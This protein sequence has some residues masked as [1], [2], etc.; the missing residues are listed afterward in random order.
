MLDLGSTESRTVNGTELAVLETGEGDPLVLVHGGVSDLRSWSGQI[1]AFSERFR[2]IAYSRRF[3]RP[4]APIPPD[5]GDPIQTH[6]DDLAA[7][8]GACRASPAHVIGHSWGGLASLMLALQRPELCR[9]LV[10]IEPPMVSMH[11]TIPPKPSRL[12]RL[13]VRSPR[14]ALAIIRFGAGAMAAADKAFRRGDDKEA[15]ERLG[16]GV[17]GD[18]AFE[19]LSE[20]RYRQV[21]DNR[22]PDRAQ[23]LHHEFP[24]LIDARFS[25]MTLPVLLINGADSPPLFGLLSDALLARLPDARKRV[26]P[27]ASHIVHEDAPAEVNSAILAFLEETR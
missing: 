20:D 26:V 3:S 25:E 8:I 13:L 16:R 24:D 2:T 4:N 15:I 1:D 18:R 19:A 23:A 12:A 22:G 6:V 7:L 14:L 21:W 10:L 5:A 17:L 9:R 11:V 27:G